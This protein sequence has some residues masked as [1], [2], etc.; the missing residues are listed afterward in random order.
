M[1]SVASSNFDLATRSYQCNMCYLGQGRIC[2][3]K[4]GIDKYSRFSVITEYIMVDIPQWHWDQVQSTGQVDPWNWYHGKKNAKLGGFTTRFQTRFGR[5]IAYPNEKFHP[6]YKRG[7]E[8]I[9]VKNG[10]PI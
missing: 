7:E 6:Y 2:T 4:K 3:D 8:K 1:L 9:Y 5:M 10:P